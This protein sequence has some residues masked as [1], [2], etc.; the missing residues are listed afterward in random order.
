MGSYAPN[1][2][3]QHGTI[4]GFPPSQH[5]PYKTSQKSVLDTVTKQVW[6]RIQQI[7]GLYLNPTHRTL[8][9]TYEPNFPTTGSART[10]EGVGQLI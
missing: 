3:Q 10:L 4:A 7:Y 6:P 1:T 8:G 2:L 5:P 9:A